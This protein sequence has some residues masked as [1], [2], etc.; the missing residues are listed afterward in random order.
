MRHSADG[1]LVSSEGLA[2]QRSVGAIRMFFL[3]YSVT[4]LWE[5]RTAFP[6]LGNFRVS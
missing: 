2:L 5:T 4:S 3:S 6:T 1:L